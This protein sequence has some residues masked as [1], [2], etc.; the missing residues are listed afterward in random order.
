M[1]KEERESQ[2]KKMYGHSPKLER[3][4]GGK[5]SVKKGEK[6]KS[7]EMGKESENESGSGDALPVHVR[8]SMDRHHLHAKHETEHSMHDHME[9]GG[10]KEMHERHEKEMKEM[11]H[12][13]EK[14]LGDGEK[15]KTPEMGKD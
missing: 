12:R 2:A 8:H 5:M 13:H 3:E 4:E 7:P 14:E 1:A 6:E 10:K 9:H 15:E 11:H